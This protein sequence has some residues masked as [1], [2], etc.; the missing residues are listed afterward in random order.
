MKGET[1]P[2]VI[3]WELLRGSWLRGMERGWPRPRPLLFPS[4]SSE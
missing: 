4:P 3:Y 1:E 2:E